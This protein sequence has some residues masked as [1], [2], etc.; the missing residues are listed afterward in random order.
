M[1]YMNIIAG[2]KKKKKTCNKYLLRRLTLI[3]FAI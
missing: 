2:R 3:A 1:Q